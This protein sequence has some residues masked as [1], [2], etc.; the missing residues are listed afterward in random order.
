[1]LANAGGLG[2]GAVIIPV[3]IFIYDFAPTDS[4]PLSKITIFAGA[5]ASVMLTACQ[6]RADDKNKLIIN[7]EMAA[8]IVPLLLIGTMVGVLASKTLPPVAITGCLC[9]YL[10]YSTY[11]MCQKAIEITKKENAARAEEN[12]AKELVESASDLNETTLED[13]AK[14]Q[15]LSNEP[16]IERKDLKVN[17]KGEPKTVNIAEKDTDL[18]VLD[19]GLYDIKDVTCCEHLKNQLPN[20]GLLL[21]SF[22]VV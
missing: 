10:V 5:I 3:Y 20:L 13:T 21:L 11:K 6:R 17:Q 9:L 2:A 18:D 16:E 15:F 1:M 4:I 14:K 7:Y 19:R 8:A 12:S 22:M